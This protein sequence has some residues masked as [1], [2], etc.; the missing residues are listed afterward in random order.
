METKYCPYCDQPLQKGTVD[1]PQENFWFLP[2]GTSL[3]YFRTRW[4]TIEGATLIRRFQL[5]KKKDMFTSY[6]IQEA[7]HCPNCKKIMI[8]YSNEKQPN[9]Q[10]LEEKDSF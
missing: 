6:P 4:T 2:E 10:N 7:Y 1:A 9:V 3:T 8:D 5:F